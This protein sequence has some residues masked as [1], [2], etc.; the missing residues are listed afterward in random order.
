MVEEVVG[1]V[2]TVRELGKISFVLIRKFPEN[3]IEQLVLKKGVT[4]DDSLSLVK[5]LYPETLVRARGEWVKSEKY[6]TGREF[7]TN[8]LE[9]LAP[10]QPT[11]YDLTGKTPTDYSTRIKYRYLDIRRPKVAA[12]LKGRAIVAQAARKVL[13]DHGFVEIWP[14]III[15]TA[16]EGGAE[17]FPLIYFEKEAFLA[18]SGQLY[19]QAAVPAFGK[20]FA[21]A[22]SFRAEKSRTR[23]HLTEFWQ[24]DVEFAFATPESIM[25]LE[26]EI[27]KGAAEALVDESKVLEL[28]G[29]EIDVP[30]RY[31]KVSYEEAID[32]LQRKGFD[33][34]W[35]DDF[36]A[37]E[38]R[39]LCA[40]FDVP[41]FITE[42]PKD[43][44]AFYYMVDEK[45]PRYARKIDFMAPGENGLELSSG[46]P[47]EHRLDVLVQRMKDQ[48]LRPE[49]F[50]WYLD[51]FK[52][53]FPPHGG[54]GIG[55]ERLT[56]ALLGL[57]KV[58]DAT[59][60]P[61]T[62]DILAP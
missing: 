58:T 9:I 24:I 4:D 52:Y 6:R 23:K 32:I 56:L 48:G 17:L 41:F 3:E 42:F 57:E 34:K 46:G 16:T 45:D 59:L 37:P 19:K 8:S 2:W 61:R 10:S 54:F 21:I 20:V 22:P 50:G 26:F 39:A 15:A 14:P 33:I 30:E 51:M 44:C 1:W 12:V 13:I 47:R 60:F 25:D 36:G 40:E 28:L 49:S 53:G 29:R 38:E 35:G 31:E 55:L 43:L 18:Q 62:P 5:E 7:V 11:P 27:Y